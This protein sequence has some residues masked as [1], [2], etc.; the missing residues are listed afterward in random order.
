MG[1]SGEPSTVQLSSRIDGLQAFLEERDR[2]YKET[3][4][5]QKALTQASFD[6]IAKAVEKAE[7]NSEKWRANANEWR[8]AMTDRESRFATK[9]EM[10]AKFVNVETQLDS[11]KETRSEHQ[12][13]SEVSTPLAVAIGSG[14]G[15]IVMYIIQKAIS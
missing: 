10:E 6:A 4:D 8:A 9:P 1:V 5:A 15:A 11:L 12:G 14:V 3:L 7:T 2:R 13:R